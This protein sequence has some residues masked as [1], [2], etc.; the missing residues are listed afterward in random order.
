MRKTSEAV[1]FSALVLYA[2]VTQLRILLPMVEARGGSFV[3]PAL[4]MHPMLWLETLLE[5]WKRRAVA[6]FLRKVKCSVTPC[7]AG[8]HGKIGRRI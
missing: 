8:I 6:F 4:L 2:L 7:G 1:V 3:C 5:H